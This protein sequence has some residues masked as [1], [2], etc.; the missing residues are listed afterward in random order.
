MIN[1]YATVNEY[2]L[3]Y[4][5]AEATHQGL[6]V[7]KFLKSLLHLSY[8]SPQTRQTLMN[9]ET[10]GIQSVY[11]VLAYNSYVLSEIE[12]PTFCQRMLADAKDMSR[13]F[14]SSSVLCTDPPTSA[15]ST[16][17]SWI[18]EVTATEA[19][20]VTQFLM[21]E[22]FPTDE[23]R[24]HIAAATHLVLKGNNPWKQPYPLNKPFQKK[25]LN[26]YD[27]QKNDQRSSQHLSRV[28]R[29][30]LPEPEGEW[31]KSIA[32]AENKSVSKALMENLIET[33]MAFSKAPLPDE[34]VELLTLSLHTENT[35]RLALKRSCKAQPLP[36][37]DQMAENFVG[38][39][40]KLNEKPPGELDKY[41]KPY[42]TSTTYKRI[43]G[44][45]IQIAYFWEKM[46]EVCYP[47]T[48]KKDI[49]HQNRLYVKEKLNGVSKTE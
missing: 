12:W 20:N 45:L 29:V 36:E 46:I 10:Q 34:L 31:I 2:T 3:K 37:L 35:I 23:I 5:E 42:A 41:R 8:Y 1:S 44:E 27:P 40:L 25:F 43:M 39:R 26:A 48:C 15:N 9:P 33:L 49:T 18:I 47:K 6:S 32:K 22:C 17:Q 11:R 38:N 21:Q 13:K 30:N 14:Y 16:N 28:I 24:R 7:N 19:L 4:I